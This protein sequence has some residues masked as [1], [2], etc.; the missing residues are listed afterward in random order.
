[1]QY[2]R[3]HASGPQSCPNLMRQMQARGNS[4]KA[5]AIVSERFGGP[6]QYTFNELN[7]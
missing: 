6:A 1:M 5:M 3:I 7:F 2:G 4:A